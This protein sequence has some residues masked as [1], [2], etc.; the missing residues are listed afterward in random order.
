[1]DNISNCAFGIDADCQGR[2]EG[3]M[4]KNAKR[5]FRTA[6]EFNL[7]LALPC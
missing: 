3:Q 4:F 7:F 5:L 2:A 6:N 1:M